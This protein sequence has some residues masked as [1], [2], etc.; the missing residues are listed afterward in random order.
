MANRDVQLVIK[1]K[2][3][4]SRAID[5]VSELIR[6]L[7]IR[8]KGA[9]ASGSTFAASLVETVA[10][11]AKMERATGLVATAVDEAESAI[12]RQRANVSETGAQLA[13]VVQQLGNAKAVIDRA[14]AGVVATLY[15][16]GDATSQI[17]SL[18][19]ARAEV[20]NLE[21]QQ[22][23]LTAALAKQKAV[24]DG[25]E[26]GFR[27]LAAT[28]NTAEAALASFGDA[29]E[30]ASLRAAVEAQQATE[31]LEAQEIATRRLR[32]AEA[33]RAQSRFAALN[34]I[35]ENPRGS[36]AAASAAV[37][38]ADFKQ[39]E[40]DLRRLMNQLDPLSAIERKLAA[41]I[42]FV[43]KVMRDQ[44]GDAVGAARAIEELKRQASE[45]S[46]AVERVGRGERGKVAP[47]GLK[48]YELTNLGY[49][50][51]D[52]VT[53]VASGTSVFQALAQQG[54]QIL[55]LMPN[56][57][58]AI[59][60]ALSNPY[61]IAA[62][63]TFGT[64]AVAINEIHENA[65]RL[66]SVEAI[67][68]GMGAG[69]GRTAE[70]MAG[71]VREVERVGFTAGEALDLLRDFISRGLNPESLDTFAKSAADYAEVTGQDLPEA[72]DQLADALSGGYKAIADFDN[73]TQALSES[74]REYIRVLFDSGREAKARA[75]AFKLFEQYF[76]SQATKMRG[77]W[78]NAVKAL[79]KSFSDLMATL[80]DSRPAR[81]FAEGMAAA[82]QQIADS[83]TEVDRLTAQQIDRQIARIEAI[84]EARA[85]RGNKIDRSGDQF[86]MQA[87]ERELANLRERRAELERQRRATGD[88]VDA[89][90]AAQAKRD[91][92]AL[93]DLRLQEQ[94]TN[95]RDSA[96]RIALAGEKA[97]QEAIDQRF[98]KEVANE[99]KRIAISKAR[100][101]EEKRAAAEAERR[102]AAF[103]KAIS[104]NGRAQLVGTAKQYVGR[105]EN[106][107]G[108]RDV[109]SSLFKAANVNIDPK[110]V[111]WCAAFVNAVLATNGLPT[112]DQATGGSDLRARDFLAYGSEVTKPEPGDIVILKRGGG[113]QGHV[114]FFQ[115]FTGN[116]DVRVLGGNQ[117]NGVNTQTFKSRDVL[118]FRRAPSAGDVAEQQAKEELK[119][120]EAQQDLNEAIDRENEKRRET[121]EILQFQQ[122]LTGEALIDAQRE[123]AVQNA[124]A[125]ARRRAADKD[126]TVSDERLAAIRQTVEAEFDLAHA[127]ERASAALEDATAAR[128]SLLGQ[129]DQ[130][131]E[132]GDTEGIAATQA[133]IKAVD[134]QMRAGI[135][136]ALAYYRSLVPSP[137]NLAEIRN[138][139]GQLRSLDI[140]AKNRARATVEKPVQ[141]LQAV[142]NGLIEQMTFARELGQTALSEELESQVRAVEGD[143]LRAVDAAIA[144]W[145][146]SS[147]P[148]AQA[149]ILNLEN[150]RNQVIAAQDEF[151]ITAG[152]IQDAFAGSLADSVDLFA[153]RLV[154]TG[155]PLK[156]LGEGLLNFAATFTRKLA[157]MGVQML[158]AKAAAKLG[159]G[160]VADGFNKAL[161]LGNTAALSAASASLSAAGATVTAG[162]AAVT[163]GAGALAA[164][165]ASLSAAASLLLAANAAGG[166]VLHGG[167]IAGFPNR[168]R[169]VS[170]LW[171]T[172]ATRY[173]SG[174]VA[175]LRPNEVPTILEKGEEVLTR[176]DPRH[177]WNG[178]MGA[179]EEGSGG[180]MALTQVLAIGEREI[181]EAMN[182]AAGD[183]LILT[184]I[185]RNRA[186]VR[187]MI[188][189]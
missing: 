47:L 80:A 83:L 36:Q 5:H 159:F 71:L 2:D 109:L 50:V 64:V 48:P 53:Q 155:N 153:Q 187:T 106:N 144:F 32:D 135:A 103:A 178:G 7:D 3:E 55:Q 45:A 158:A 171:F 111:A 126:L 101:E 72:A 100:R 151:I 107:A 87:E 95:A 133:A 184:A 112:V 156:A 88:L 63:V 132:L 23:R 22:T 42:A 160:G 186:S 150:L 35:T 176:S 149:A 49:Q 147:G 34:N 182:N 179:G 121:A 16:G 167:G 117:S 44:K 188:N 24:L 168:S 138:L 181:V 57:G 67:L 124:L 170:P 4:A 25:Q 162:G 185:R 173:H 169:K 136:T 123:A 166:G 28:A 94:I 19:A 86:L 65:K 140:D 131:L 98:S 92:D 189:D 37:F 127:R 78:G 164:A 93:R 51:N 110:M 79:D 40:A 139:E 31:A 68:E 122:G 33:A 74:E 180:K 56:V 104:E 145:A 161:G 52:L 154:E 60:S 120:A 172:A 70:Q 61:I 8:Q 17:A 177:R 142:R 58:A 137:K 15:K 125:E 77:S 91:K 84:R 12:A 21:A 113:G 183:K 82:V 128:D 165:A 96:T 20:D 73:K 143:L 27:Q 108:D 102:N 13:A 6:T 66:N 130:S 134:D 14:Q 105:N 157:E 85:S 163:T 89:E 1:A 146:A 76:D 18:K 141:D 99:R 175:G 75:E 9:S 115:G 38:E 43:N 69:A 62:A 152:Q 90:S 46:A 54:G 97:Y 41:D 11:L 119:R 114:G 174:G 39:Q 10:Q 59:I 118:G 129:L 26:N 116:G 30:R 148:E 29:S 81:A